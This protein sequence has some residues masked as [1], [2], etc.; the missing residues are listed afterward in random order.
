MSRIV[1]GIRISLMSE[2]EDQAVEV[3]R[4]V[5]VP[6]QGGVLYP[7]PAGVSGNPAG[8]QK[9]SGNLVKALWK[10]HV[11]DP[12]VAKAIWDEYLRLCLHARSEELR[13]KMLMDM[14]DRTGVPRDT[15][16][17]HSPAAVAQVVNIIRNSP[18]L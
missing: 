4:A 12:E 1:R 3:E 8:R 6:P 2:D 10:E 7:W 11:D 18:E 13:A 9:G 17:N 16:G 5:H 15:S 14:L